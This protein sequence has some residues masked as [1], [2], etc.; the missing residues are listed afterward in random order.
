M[1][2]SEI[3]EMTCVASSDSRRRFGTSRAA[4]SADSASRKY[5]IRTVPTW[6]VALTRVTELIVGPGNAGTAQVAENVE[7]NPLKFDA[8]RKLV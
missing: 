3:L 2:V 6:I 4:A 1:N 5:V 8:V 7:L